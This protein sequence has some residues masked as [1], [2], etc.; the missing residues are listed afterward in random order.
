M[1]HQNKIQHSKRNAVITFQGV[2][3]QTMQVL[4]GDKLVFFSNSEELV[5]SEN[6]SIKYTF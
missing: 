3:A 1:V 5:F 4:L 2:Y 6:R